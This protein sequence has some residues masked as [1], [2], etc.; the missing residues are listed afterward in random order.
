[1]KPEASAA[2]RTA[3]VWAGTLLYAFTAIPGVLAATGRS[4]DA[5]GLFFGFLLLVALLSTTVGVLAG[6][7]GGSPGEAAFAVV[8]SAVVSIVAV[9]VAA[10]AGSDSTDGWG[11]FAAFLF[12]GGQ[13]VVTAPAAFW[14]ASVA[15][16]AQPR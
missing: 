7:T 2:L 14:A 10:G 6:R 8:V 5:G 3:A 1:M 16:R 9:F 4:D 15:G 11:V 12:A 13:A